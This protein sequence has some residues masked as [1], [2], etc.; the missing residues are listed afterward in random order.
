MINEY[1]DEIEPIPGLPEE[2]PENERILWQG[3]PSAGLIAQHI[4]RLR[5]LTAYFVLI[6]CTQ[7]G[8]KMYRGTTLENSLEGAALVLG[9]GAVAIAIF[10]LLSFAY[11]KTTVY[12]I[13]SKRLAMRFGVALP[14]VVNIPLSTVTSADMRRFPDGSGDVVFT[15]DPKKRMSYILLWPHVRPWRFLQPQPSIRCLGSLE[16]ACAA[17]AS[18]V[19]NANKN[20]SDEGDVGAHKATLASA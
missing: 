17:L 15:L 11:A 10:A 2:P 13:T 3:R 5:W 20:A 14:M 12:T 9:L 19:P 18:A 16:G 1:K 6:A 8:L 4:F 7:A